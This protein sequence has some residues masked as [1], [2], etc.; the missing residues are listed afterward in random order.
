MRRLDG[1]TVVLTG[2]AGGIGS[3]V[4]ARLRESG[5]TIVGVD[6]V[7]CPACSE[8]IMADLSNEPGLAALSTVLAGRHIDIL[9]NIA[10]VQYFGPMAR[11]A[12]ASIWL[13]Y[14]VNLIA[15]AT[16]IRAVLPQMQ[17]RRAGQI[18][19]I[20][21]VMGSINYPFFAAYSSS[22]AGLKGLS[23]GLRRELHGM[24]IAVTHIA[25][26][27]VRTA[28]NNSDVHRFMDLTGMVA[29]EPVVVADRIVAAIIGRE[30]DVAIGFRER[31]F[32]R[33]NALLPRVID[34]GLSAQTVKARG[35]FPSQ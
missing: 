20:G 9:V 15:P 12:A 16:L 25:P 33:I 32:M 19:N 28:F 11:Q 5:A 3:L 8:T 24:G 1:Q 10:G 4:A 27:A 26:R 17:A 7:D 35:L 14:V 18:V 21:S 29:D 30:R 22:K 31:M 34:A 6:R 13:N 2:A 23:E